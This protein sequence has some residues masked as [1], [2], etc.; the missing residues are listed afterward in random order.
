MGKNSK[1][2]GQNKGKKLNN[3]QGKGKNQDPPEEVE[4][5]SSDDS[6]N[7]K[8]YMFLVKQLSPLCN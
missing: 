5:R 8:V 4:S 2:K 1:K 7:Y 6:S 3:D